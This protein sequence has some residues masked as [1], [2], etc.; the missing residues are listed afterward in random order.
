V[1]LV[2][3]DRFY[4]HSL[5]TQNQGQMDNTSLFGIFT[6]MLLI[7]SISFYTNSE[8]ENSKLNELKI[9]V[10]VGLVLYRM[11]LLFFQPPECCNF[12]TYV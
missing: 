9:Y 1:T 8:H 6:D 7:Q 4:R 11:C 3:V 2:K 12:L 10:K 5:C